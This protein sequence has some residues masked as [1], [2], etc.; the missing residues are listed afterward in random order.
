M[1]LPAW[2]PARA[3]VPYP[4][5]LA[6]VRRVRDQIDRE[7][8]LPLDVAALAHGVGMP[9]REL[10]SEFTRAYGMSPGAYLAVRHREPATQAGPAPAPSSA[11][12]G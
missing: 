9:P 12:A 10:V 1:C 5:E 11:L 3:A 2:A 7:H 8:T 4:H 6:R